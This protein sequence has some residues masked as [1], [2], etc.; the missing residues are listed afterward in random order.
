MPPGGELLVRGDSCVNQ[1][2]Q[3]DKLLFGVQF[4]PETDPETMRFI[5]SARRALWRDRV[6]FDLDQRLDHLPETPLAGNIL[7]NF[8]Q[9]VVP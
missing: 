2:F 6:S 3:C 8:A 9:F 7:R 4:H 5:W 1:G